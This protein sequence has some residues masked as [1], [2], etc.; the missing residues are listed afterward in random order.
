M[1][2]GEI[3]PD[4]CLISSREFIEAKDG[5]DE[6]LGFL[7]GLRMMMSIIRFYPKPNTASGQRVGVNALF[8]L[9]QG[10]GRDRHLC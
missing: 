3:S 2:H 9:K 4:A 5:N 8:V 1:C 10:D 7:D 6:G